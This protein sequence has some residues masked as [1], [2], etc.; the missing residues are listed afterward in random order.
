MAAISSTGASPRKRYI[1][2]WNELPPVSSSASSVPSASSR[3]ATCDA[4]VEPEPAA[5]AVGH[6]ELGDHRDAGRR[7]RPRTASAISRASRARFSI[8]PPQPSLRLLSRGL[9]ERADEVAVAEVQL[10]GVEAGVGGEPAGVGEVAD[11]ALR[12]R[13]RSRATVN[14]IACG[15]N[16]RDGARPLATRVG[17]DRPGV[18]ELHAARGARRRAWRRRTRRRPGTAS[19]R[20]TISPGAPRPSSRHRAV[21]ERRHADAAV[22]R[23]RGGSR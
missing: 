1:G 23:P 18:A 22:R 20:T 5:D 11:D 3:R 15:A 19:S 12:C 10:D 13:R 7:R 16:T 17:G 6:V 2:F 14:F 8:E 9:E 4:V 21:R